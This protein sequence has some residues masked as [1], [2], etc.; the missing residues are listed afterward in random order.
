MKTLTPQQFVGTLRYG[1]PANPTVNE[2]A[3]RARFLEK[4]PAQEANIL[5][6]QTN[7]GCTCARDLIASISNDA[8]KL[9][10]LSY[11]EGEEVTVLVPTQAMGKVIVI[12]D[13]DES[14]A[15]L[16]KR[17]QNEM[18]MFRGLTVVPATIDGVAKLRVFFF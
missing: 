3:K 17:L 5:S 6:Y 2:V 9:Q 12:D 15:A 16:I 10:N 13:T 8:N 1:N 18:T 11:I 14:Y 4:Y 7:P